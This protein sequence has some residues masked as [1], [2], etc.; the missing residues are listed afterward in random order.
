M[1]CYSVCVVKKTS[2]SGEASYWI[3]EGSVSIVYHLFTVWYVVCWWPKSP[4]LYQLIQPFQ[5]FG[6]TPCIP[7]VYRAYVLY[8]MYPHKTIGIS[9]GFYCE[10]NI[11]I[12]L[13]KTAIQL[14]PDHHC[15]RVCT[16][17]SEKNMCQYR[18]TKI[19]RQLLSVAGRH[20]RRQQYHSIT[21]YNTITFCHFRQSITNLL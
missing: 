4:H 11:S 2:S 13:R 21:V 19:A 17:K 5:I 6:Y 18:R 12:W 14:V 8:C 1:A 9:N 7:Q 3:V 20:C 10:Y 16:W 15:C